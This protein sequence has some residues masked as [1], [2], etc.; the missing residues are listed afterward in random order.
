[1][2]VQP[3]RDPKT[4]DLPPIVIAGASR[5]FVSALHRVLS[6]PSVARFEAAF[7]W[8]GAIGDPAG[9]PAIISVPTEAAP[10]LEAAA[11]LLKK[12]T[13]TPDEV[14]S[15]PIV[16]VRHVPGDPLGQISVQTMRRGRP[17]EVRV[18]LSND[19]LAPT[20]D[21]ARDG[22]TVVVEGRVRRVPGQPLTID[23]PLR[24]QPVDETYLPQSLES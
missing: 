3:A 4:S 22:R 15:G 5:E 19:G 21:W 8:A 7:V 1:M 16:E 18:T 12:S 17:A 20:F 11:R 13:Y 2:I 24:V 10:L 9:V 6:D 14:I 23:R